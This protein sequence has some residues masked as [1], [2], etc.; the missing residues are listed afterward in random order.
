MRAR[1][2]AA[3]ALAWFAVPVVPMLIWAGADRW[4]APALLPQELGVRGWQAAWDAGVLAAGARSLLLGAAVAAIATPLGATAGR[5]LGWGRG[6]SRALVAVV[7]LLPVLL[8][9]FAVSIGLDVLLLRLQVPGLVATIAVLATFALPYCAFTIGAGYA[10]T[11]RTVE[12]QARALGARPRTA[13]RRATLPALRR[14]LLVAAVLAFLVG[15]SDYVVTLLLGGGQLVTL[16]VLLGSAA[17]G[18]GNEPTVA[19]L[20]VATAVPPVLLLGAVVLL[21]RRRTRSAV[22]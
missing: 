16:P 7:M 20:A 22:A 2:Y 6:W 11:D 8:P 18:T 3:L 15:W 13:R 14:P 21:A 10:A 5:V 19:A 17:S 1:A 4:T 12:D 9:P